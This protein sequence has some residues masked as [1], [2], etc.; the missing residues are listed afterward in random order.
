[1]FDR[2]LN[3]PPLQSKIEANLTLLWRRSLSYRNQS[4]DLLCKSMVWFLNDR[5][6]CHERV[7]KYREP[8]NTAAVLFKYLCPF[9]RYQRVKHPNNSFMHTSLL[10][11]KWNRTLFWINYHLHMFEKKLFQIFQET[12]G[13]LKKGTF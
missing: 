13:Q 5:H 3:K 2:V 12:L 9:S 1:M 7:N 11:W 4:N 6:L 8:F 10:S